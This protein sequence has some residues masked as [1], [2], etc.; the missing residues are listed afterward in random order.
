MFRR[1][2]L[3]VN[4]AGAGSRA[5]QAVRAGSKRQQ[6]LVEP[7]V[8]ALPVDAM[9]FQDPV[10][11]SPA[12]SR[13]AQFR[14]VAMADRPQRAGPG[15]GFVRTSADQMPH[16]GHH[17]LPASSGPKLA[18]AVLQRTGR[19]FHCGRVP[20]LARAERRLDIR[21]ELVLTRIVARRLGAAEVRL[22]GV[23][24]R[25]EIQEHRVVIV[26]HTPGACLSATSASL[27]GRSIAATCSRVAP[28]RAAERARADPIQGDGIQ[29]C[30]DGTAGVVLRVLHSCASRGSDFPRQ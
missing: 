10:S 16:S 17:E 22:P 27:S 24:H 2:D 25:C 14:I 7:T 20:L 29:P 1:D 28:G 3:M 13:L 18:D 15:H 4:A 6:P 5:G 8:P 21:D 19:E 23:E 11:P 30:R 9:N 12:G 26:T